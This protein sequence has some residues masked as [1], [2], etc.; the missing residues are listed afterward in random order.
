DGQ[1]G[2]SE[3]GA[4][5]PTRRAA[6]KARGRPARLSRARRSAREAR[7]A[8]RGPGQGPAMGYPGRPMATS[9]AA[10]IFRPAEIPDRALSQGFAVAL[11]GWDVASPRL[12]VAA[13][14]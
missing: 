11:G 10:L 7:G 9:F 8:S 2:F 3:H 5:Y 12:L 14:P 13:L 4:L 6:S 1:R